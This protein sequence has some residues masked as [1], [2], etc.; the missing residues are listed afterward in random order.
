MWSRLTNAWL[1]VQC[2]FTWKK[3]NLGLIEWI[4]RR[5]KRSWGLLHM[6]I[7]IKSNQSGLVRG[8]L[9][10]F[11]IATTLYKGPYPYAL[12]T[13]DLNCLLTSAQ[14]FSGLPYFF[15]P[16]LDMILLNPLMTMSTCLFLLWLN[17]LTPFSRGLKHLNYND[18]N[19]KYVSP[20]KVALPMKH[21]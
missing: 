10:E 1:F 20:N 17:C 18:Y 14:L 6:I 3:H 12:V 21:P 8:S 5:G 19:I 4:M 7:L 15:L 13:T 2:R 9:H 16:Y 11:M